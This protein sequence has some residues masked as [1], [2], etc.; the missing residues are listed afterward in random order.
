[1]SKAFTYTI[2]STVIASK[3]LQVINLSFNPMVSPRHAITSSIHNRCKTS[4]Q[5]VKTILT[6][7]LSKDNSKDIKRAATKVVHK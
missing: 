3:S 6:L 4:R 5:M 2:M 1:M 7:R